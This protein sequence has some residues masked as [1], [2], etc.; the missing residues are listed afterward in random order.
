MLK[1]KVGDKVILLWPSPRLGKVFKRNIDD[2]TDPY[3]IEIK[4]KGTLCA[5]A[6][7]DLTLATDLAK[8]LLLDKEEK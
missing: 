6:E 5:C 2:T 1:F 8:L 7:S 3:L 4:D